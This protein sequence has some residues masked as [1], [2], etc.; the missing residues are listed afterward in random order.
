M[1]NNTDHFDAG[2]FTAGAASLIEILVLS[3]S[4]GGL[5]GLHR[6]RQ[7]AA[8]RAARQDQVRARHQQAR[9]RAQ[10]AAA[11]LAAALRRH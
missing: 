10:A 5:R 4:L 11:A 3:A 6:I 2:S 8:F 1:A 9:S 7:D